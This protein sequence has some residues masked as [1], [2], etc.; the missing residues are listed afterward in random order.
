MTP[1][2]SRLRHSLASVQLFRRM[3]KVSREMKPWP[4]SVDTLAPSA[5][6]VPSLIF[7]HPAYGA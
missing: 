5:L 6:T 7:A 1:C 2:V 4:L 3:A